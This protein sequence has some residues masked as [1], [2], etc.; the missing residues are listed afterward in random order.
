MLGDMGSPFTMSTVADGVTAM[1][2][3][4]IAP[5][6][7]TS[8]V[9]LTTTDDGVTWN[10]PLQM[11]VDFAVDSFNGK[12]IFQVPPSQGMVVAAQGLGYMN[13]NDTDLI[14][15]IEIAFLQHTYHR[16][17]PVYLDAVANAI[18]PTQ[19]LPPV[20]ENMVAILAV[21]ESYWALAT[22]KAQNFTIDT[23]DGTV[24]PLSQQYEHIMSHIE[25]LNAR[26]EHLANL[27]GTGLHAIE[28][29]TL[30]RHSRVTGTLVPVYR[31]QELEDRYRVPDRVLPPVPVL[32][33]VRV[34]YR[35]IYDLDAQY[36]VND[37]V[38]E[39]GITFIALT[40]NTGIDPGEDVMSGN[41]WCGLNW[42]MT[43]IN[44]TGGWWSGYGW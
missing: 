18:P 44:D 16:E 28:I 39:G 12:L 8:I 34:H 40:D 22:A 32:A 7:P 29:Q 26:Y 20:E 14:D 25:Q 23:G 10:G 11:G 2:D 27:V 17:P 36:Y 24:I 33:D 5:V 37:E 6:E 31:E 19:V 42:K 15:F 4:N 9:V 38:V 41:G 13:W 35:G 3:L 30:R 21:V 43:K 1:F